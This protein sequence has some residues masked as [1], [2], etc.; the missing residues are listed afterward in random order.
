M[1][2]AYDNGQPSALAA[3][4]ATGRAYLAFARQVSRPLPGDV[5]K[6]PAGQR[7]S[8]PRRWPRG[9]ARGVLERPPRSSGRTSRPQSA[10]PRRCSRPISGRCAT[11]WSNSSLR[12]TPGAAALSAR[13]PAGDRHRHLPARAWACCRPTG[14]RECPT[15]PRQGVGFRMTRRHSASLLRP[16]SE[17]RVRAASPHDC[18]Q[19]RAPR[20]TRRSQSDCQSQRTAWVSGTEPARRGSRR[21]G[22]GCRSSSTGRPGRCASTGALASRCR[23]VRHRNRSCRHNRRPRPST[24]C[25]SRSLACWSS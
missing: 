11:A 14:E 22:S 8:R 15:R 18:P 12:G 5:R 17:G 24:P 3:F 25:V 23:R 7:P 9:R 16:M 6:R 19:P 1:E 21:P 10:R 20:S 4:E 2:Y 13:G